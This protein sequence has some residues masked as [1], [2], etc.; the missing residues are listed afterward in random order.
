VNIRVGLLIPGIPICGIPAR[1]KEFHCATADSGGSIREADSARL[2]VFF[3]ARELESEKH[4]AAV[5]S[6]PAVDPGLVD[7]PV[8]TVR[9]GFVDLNA[10][11]GAED[12]AHEICVCV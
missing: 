11:F 8:G 4:P 3:G 6:V 10:D 2:A 9:V 7:W 5:G 1:S 12:F